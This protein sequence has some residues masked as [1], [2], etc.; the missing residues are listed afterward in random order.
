LSSPPGSRSLADIAALDVTGEFP[1]PFGQP[2]AMEAMGT[3]AAPLLAGFAFTSIGLVLQVQESL[4]WPDQALVLLVVASLLF[5]TSLQ[6]S[7]NARRHWV[8]PDQWAAWLGLAPTAARRSALQ[9]HWV[10]YVGQYRR[11]IEVAR[12]AYNLAI[13]ALLVA[14]AVMLVPRGS[15]D[16]WRAVGIGL[17]A[18]GALGEVAWAFAA[19]GVRRRPQ[20]HVRYSAVPDDGAAPAMPRLKPDDA[21][22]P[23]GPAS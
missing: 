9:Q 21:G 10:A 18:L 12:L 5:I 7:F 11:W 19:T 14:L 23:G 13:V 16:A 2:A 20:A 1:R 6:A 22:R 4:R 3:V 8:P 17:A 15:I